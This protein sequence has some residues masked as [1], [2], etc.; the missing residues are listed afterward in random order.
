MIENKNNMD[1]FKKSVVEFFKYP[2]QKLKDDL[3]I[4][5]LEHKDINAFLKDKKEQLITE[6][7]TKLLLNLYNS[8]LKDKDKDEIKKKVDEGLKYKKEPMIL[9]NNLSVKYG[10]KITYSYFTNY[11]NNYNKLF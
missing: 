9:Y 11:Y 10:D 5:E 8:I 2:K 3:E 7:F 4:L 6:V 1:T